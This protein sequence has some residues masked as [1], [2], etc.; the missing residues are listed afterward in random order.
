MSTAQIEVKGNWYQVGKMNALAQLH[1]VRRL[2]P[3]IVVV[4]LSLDML[5]QG[6]K[7]DMGDL[8]ASA[9]P[10]MEIVSKMPNEDFDYVVFAC[11]DVCRRKQGDAW[12]PVALAEAKKLMFQDLEF[13]EILRLVIEVLKLNLGS[14]LTEPNDEAGSAKS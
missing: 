14:F 9:G 3:A 6:L 1:V 5:R 13:L 2:G 12:A 4:G 11:L 10:V 7:V 8:V